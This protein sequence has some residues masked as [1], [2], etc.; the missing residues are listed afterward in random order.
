MRGQLLF[1]NCYAALT[2]A[3]CPP[4]N[5]GQLKNLLQVPY[6]KAVEQS[7]AVYDT[8][9]L[10]IFVK[11]GIVDALGEPAHVA[12]GLHIRK[13]HEKLDLSPQRLA[14]ILRYL[15]TQGW[16]HEREL[17]VFA[18]NRSA[19]EL[20]SGRNGRNWIMYAS[21]LTFPLYSHRSLW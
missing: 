18:L 1:T 8:A 17:N 2:D 5:Q 13:L 11:T 21:I 20:L 6:E 10:D 14:T 3:T 4:S 16:V 12:T 9:C 7:C 19:L 15:A